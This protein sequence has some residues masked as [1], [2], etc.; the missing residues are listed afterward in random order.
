MHHS[1][2]PVNCGLHVTFEPHSQVVDF[3]TDV[4][5]TFPYNLLGFRIRVINLD[6]KRVVV[7]L[8]FCTH[9]LKASH[10][11]KPSEHLW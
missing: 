8:S 7:P 11:M 9:K 10:A 2:F 6:V 1:P 3:Q 5:S 4:P